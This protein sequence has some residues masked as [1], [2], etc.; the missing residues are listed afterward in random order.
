MNNKEFSK[1]LKESDHKATT[2]THLFIDKQIKRKNKFRPIIKWSLASI[3]SLLLV[4]TILVNT[5]YQFYVFAIKTP[6]K[7][8]AELLK[9]ME[10]GP[11]TEYDEY[12]KS[13]NYQKIDRVFKWEYTDF[14]YDK[15]EFAKIEIEVEILGIIYDVNSATIIAKFNP[16][17]PAY[18]GGMIMASNDGDYIQQYFSAPL[19]V[20]ID[21]KEAYF[22]HTRCLVFDDEYYFI[23][24]LF[25]DQIQADQT[26]EIYSSSYISIIHAEKKEPLMAQEISEKYVAKPKII[27]INKV[28]GQEDRRVEITNLIVGKLFIDVEI[29]NLSQEYK[30]VGAEL[31]NVS[32][33]DTAFCFQ[34]SLGPYCYLDN[35]CSLRI[36][37]FYSSKDE[38]LRL[39]FK[40]L[41]WEN[42]NPQKVDLTYDLGTNKWKNL[43]KG[44]DMYKFE[45]MEDSIHI[46]IKISAEFDLGSYV[47]VNTGYL[48]NY[49]N[50]QFGKYYGEESKSILC[51]DIERISEI[52]NEE[53]SF[54]AVFSSGEVDEVDFK[55]DIE[56]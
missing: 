49:V 52:G 3:M 18:N 4:F 53:I 17:S 28:V 5:S 50:A 48:S 46:D 51:I 16:I 42:K 35:R 24:Y 38:I 10:K 20:S 41:V 2:N 47:I 14:D 6:L 30:L 37:D 9:I 19:V 31:V 33:E 44:W 43:P 7:D 40:N 12:L 23:D 32:I 11:E 22:S 25:E 56:R 36:E 29:V 13:N 21:N 34:T 1:W 39:D 15:N 45:I 8:I 54:T 27:P 55:I 26:I